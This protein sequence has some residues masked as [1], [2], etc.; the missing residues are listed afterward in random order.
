VNITKH[1]NSSAETE[2]IGVIIG[3]QLRGGEVIELKSD[4]GGGKTT[5]TKGIVLGA[6]SQAVVGSPTFTVTKQYP[7]EAAGSLHAIV[8]ADMYRLQD[9]GIIKHELAD[10]LDEHTALV[11]EWAESVDSVLPPERIVV[12]II[13]TQTEHDRSVTI[14]IPDRYHYIAK[15]FDA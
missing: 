9:P 14:Q 6:G 15:G 8:H 1:T 3:Q 7:I 4:V 11:I 12:E 10:I 5:L 2:Q 13:P